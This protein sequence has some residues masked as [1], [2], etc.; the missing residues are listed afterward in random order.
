MRS[1]ILAK[2]L[3]IHRLQALEFPEICAGP[4]GSPQ[5]CSFCMFVCGVQCGPLYAAHLHSI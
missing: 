3:E 4:F 5:H 2:G 1:R